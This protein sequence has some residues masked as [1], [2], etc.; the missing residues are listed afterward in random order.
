MADHA[1]GYEQAADDLQCYNCGMRGHMFFA[2]PEDT[3][4]VPAGL[5]ASRKRQ[6]SVNDHPASIKRTRGPVVTHYPPPP[7]G[8]Q[9]ISPSPTSYSPRRG[10]ERFYVGPS[11]GP[12]TRQPYHQPLHPGQHSQY[13]P[14]STGPSASQG[15]SYGNSSDVY[16]HHYSG[17]PR[18]PPP[19]TP[20]RPP[21]YDQY[22]QSRSGP[23]PPVSYGHRYSAP[24]DRHDKHPAG[25]PQ[26]SPSAVAHRTPLQPHFEYYPPAPGADNYYPGP[27]PPYPPP[28]SDVYRNPTYYGHDPSPARLYTSGHGSPSPGAYPHQPLQYLPSEPPQYHSRYDDRFAD[29]PPVQL[30]RRDTH[31]QHDKR[32]PNENRQNRER[33]GRRMR[34]GPSKGRSHSE[35]QLPDRLGRLSSPVTSTP[36]VQSARDSS[37]PDNKKSQPSF[38]DGLWVDT[39]NTGKYTAEDFSWDEETIFKE[40]PIKFTKDLIKE[41][42]PV[43]WTDDPIM[44]PKYD[45][46]TITSRYINS[47][48]VDDFA[49]SVRETKAW[50]LMQYHPAF[51][52]PTEV[53]KEKLEYYKSALNPPPAY[54][55]QTLQDVNNRSAS[56]R[57]RGKSWGIRGR[58]GP[59]NRHP[60][61]HQQNHISSDYQSSRSRPGPTKRSW[62]P[63]VYRDSYEPEE[64]SQVFAKKPRIS[65]PEPGEVRETD[66]Q[67]T[68][69]TKSTS[70]LWKQEYHS[71]HQDHAIDAIQ[72]S[73]VGP[74]DI[75]SESGG[76]RLSLQTS[77]TPPPAPSHISGSPS[78]LS[79]RSSSRGSP[80]R[81]SSRHSSRSNLSRPTSRR[82]SAGSAGS[83]LTPNER[84]LLGMRPY[85]SSSDTGRDSPIPQVN[86]TPTR[87]RQRPAK[88]HAVYQRRW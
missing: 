12:P 38:V 66:D 87:S 15:F 71:F 3:R 31:P 46:E 59:Q 39:K 9:H 75:R 35:R 43:E 74:P 56:G 36:S 78:R 16:E 85:S 22:D 10:Y 13:P 23:S 73:G 11:P 69:T 83:P 62:D 67:P 52:P 19:E 60:Q 20:F 70:P 30:Q 86:G 81:P 55:K 53:R 24:L 50:Q 79:S 80:T 64:E 72:E 84:E 2:C 4:R 68:P 42:L 25:P 65:S 45:K 41:P 18:V 21:Q 17:A 76:H 61:H 8:L 49:L 88:L 63:A 44:P 48:N 28:P 51:L 5:E 33:H 27:P 58:G 82:S 47:T 6:A 32:R 34:H 26:S 77:L 29:Q 7:L 40:L 1:P 37:V 57:P 54:S 14:P